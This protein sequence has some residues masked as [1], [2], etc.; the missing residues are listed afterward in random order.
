[1]LIFSA[2][3]NEFVDEI[4][5]ISQDLIALIGFKEIQLTQ[6]GSHSRIQWKKITR[7]ALCN[8]VKKDNYM[9][10]RSGAALKMSYFQ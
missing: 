6:I 7:S 8:N 3:Q 1:M 5:S 4:Q 9:V 2:K 10:F